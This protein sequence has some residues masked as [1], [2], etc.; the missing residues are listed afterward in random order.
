[1]YFNDKSLG[2]IDVDAESYEYKVEVVVNGSTAVSSRSIFSILL[3]AKQNPIMGDVIDL[4]WNHY[5]GWPDPDYTVYLGKNEG[6][7]WTDVAHVPPTTTQVNPTKDT[8]YNMLNPGLDK[9]DYRICVL[10]TNPAFLVYEAWSNCI[11]F[12][13]YETIPPPPPPADTLRIPNVFTPNNDG[14]NDVFYIENAE[15]WDGPRSVQIF[16]R[17]GNVV[18][19]TDKYDNM[20]AWDGT[21]PSGKKVADGVYFYVLDFTHTPTGENFQQNGNITIFGN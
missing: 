5:L 15:T 8:V 6:G 7:V 1:M 19:K 2:A 21:D 18:Y 20:N 10:A 3:K 9:G 16:N 11:P 4:E 14:Q 12:T 17:W 13:I